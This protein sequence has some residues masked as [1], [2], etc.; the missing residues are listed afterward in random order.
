MKT[1]TLFSKV[2]DQRTARKRHRK[3][4][5]H[6]PAL[7]SLEA[8]QLLTAALAW[9]GDIL[10]V[11]G[12][13]DN[14]F[15]AVQQDELGLKIFTEDSVFTDLDGRSLNDA[16]S[17]VVSGQSGN[18]VLAAYK[19]T[20][21]I[22]LFGN[23]GNDVLYSSESTNTLLGGEGFDWIHAADYSE[24]S[25]N[26]FGVG[27]LNLSAEAFTTVPQFDAVGRI[28]LQ[29]D[30]DGEI[31]LAGNAVDVIGQAAVTKDG[32][33]VEVTG[34]LEKW[35]DAFGIADFDL[36]AASLTLNGGTDVIGG[37]GYHV[38]LTSSL[39]VS[40]TSV[41]VTADVEVSE[42][43]TAASFTGRVSDWD[44]A[45]DIDGL[46]LTEVELTGY[47]SVDAANNQQFSIAI[48]ADM[49][50]EGTIIDVAG[51]V[52]VA[53]DQFDIHLQGAI[54]SWDD[55][56]GVG[57]LDL[58]RGEVVVDARSNRKND[59]ELQIDVLADVLF[60]DTAV[61]VAGQ[62]DISP[63]QIDAL[64]SGS[65]DNW[66]D[67]FGV[68]GLNLQHAEFEIAGSTDRQGSHELQVDVLGNLD[69]QGTQVGVTGSI[70]IDPNRVSGTLKGSV[71]AE[72]ADAFGLEGL[73]LNDTKLA[74]N[75]ISD[76]A[77]GNSL[78]VELTADLNVN[79][80]D[81]AVAGQ[82]EMESGSV[83]ASLK[84]IVAGTWSAAFG[85]AGLELLDTTLKVAGNKSATKSEVFL[86]VAS[87][88]NVL[89]TDIAI[90]GAFAFTPAGL[91]TSFTGSDAGE[92]V[93]AFS[94][95]GLNLKDLDLSFGSGT[96]PDTGSESDT[97]N[98]QLD[99]DL[100][101]FGGYLPM[102][103]DLAISPAGIDLSFSPPSSIDFTDILGIPGFSLDD[104]DLTVITGTDGFEVTIDSTMDFG[105]IDVDFTG[106]FAVSG[107]EV[108][109]S[110][111]GQ[112]AE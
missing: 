26:A 36:S 64:F 83:S 61:E 79:G 94:I 29:V 95:P 84:G 41:F 10:E 112:V 43:I 60:D 52:E 19:T 87:G 80:T 102:I 56:F 111:T 90:N 6:A 39:D 30:I 78:A 42:A 13:D 38:E 93:N 57:R 51:A 65:I 71:D 82:I 96:N 23:V 68:D 81:V 40:G 18:D 97:L 62:V 55:A 35:D 34:D 4:K 103:G 16:Q 85:I 24:S 109:A 75:A 1:P 92:W 58:R 25:E 21:P 59:R 45:F 32:V 63:N 48:D 98:I 99:T 17:V 89:G 22:T 110:L 5:V 69:V 66:D 15:I 37:N 107:R 44:D 91:I 70:D 2:F 54:E 47:G 108:Q 49:M 7:E 33:A 67:A 104:A 77:S 72:W 27:G 11:T 86:E 105:N 101:L 53:P 106:A 20:V 73:D 14:D 88:I 100:N 28:Q 50:V 74:V 8:R 76:Q 31:D 9:D 46:D 3:T 12:S